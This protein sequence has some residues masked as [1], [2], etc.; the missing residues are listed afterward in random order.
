M[1]EWST[2][3]LDPEVATKSDYVVNYHYVRLSTG[4]LSA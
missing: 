1:K 4:C 3:T 2:L